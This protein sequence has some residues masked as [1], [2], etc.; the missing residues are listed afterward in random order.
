MNIWERYP[1]KGTHYEAMAA[2]AK[3]KTYEYT[4]Y[5]G[6]DRDDWSTGTIQALTLEDAVRKAR[7]DLLPQGYTLKGG[8][9]KVVQS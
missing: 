9:V 6:R 3:V 1:A 8:S 2:K 4:C 5:R 7:I